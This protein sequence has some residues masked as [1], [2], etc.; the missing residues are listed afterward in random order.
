MPRTKRVLAW[1]S[2]DGRDRAAV[3]AQLKQAEYAACPRCGD[4]LEARP[5]TRLAALLPS[6]ASGHDL[7][8][9]RCRRFYARVT[10]TERSRY[11][12]RIRRLARAVMR[13]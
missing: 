5:E 13:V 11:H 7:E 12:L 2:F 10:L 8:C 3:R 6:G 9:R 1:R 4:C